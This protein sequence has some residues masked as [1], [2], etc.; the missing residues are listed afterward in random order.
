MHEDTARPN[1]NHND[2]PKRPLHR[3]KVTV[4]GDSMLKYLNPTKLRQNL[5]KSVLVRTFP[6][7]KV[8]DMKH[9]VQPTLATSP[10]TLVRHVGTNDHSQKTTQNVL[11]ELTSLG[12][13]I[14]GDSP[15]TKLVIS[16]IITR[17]DITQI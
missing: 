16:A 15:E 7:A 3:S 8:T 1:D 11:E 10:E 13:A 4:V 14:S 2:L 9:Y 17:A 12:Q 6:G 5:R